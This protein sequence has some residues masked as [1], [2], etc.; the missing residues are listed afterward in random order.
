MKKN[1]TK[2]D[3]RVEQKRLVKWLRVIIVL[4]IAII[5]IEVCYIGL[6]Y[7]N[8]SKSIIYTDTL[9]SFKETKDGYLVVGNS[10]FKK[11]KFNDYQKEYNKAKFAKY[12]KDFDVEFES[13][14][15]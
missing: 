13:A 15:Y 9:N 14:L 1:K 6:S 12:N 3:L 5:A 2:K 4:C 7:Y 8:R 10:D 11:S